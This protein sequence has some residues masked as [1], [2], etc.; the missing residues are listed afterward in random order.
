MD[1]NN[2][3]EISTN[4]TFFDVTFKNEEWKD[5][6]FNIPS[7][8]SSKT[9]KVIGTQSKNGGSINS[10]PYHKITHEFGALNGQKSYCVSKMASENNK[11][12]LNDFKLSKIS[13]SYDCI[14]LVGDFTF[15]FYIIQDDVLYLSENVFIKKAYQ[16]TSIQN[17]DQKPQDFLCENG[18]HPKFDQGILEYGFI[19]LSST[20]DKKSQYICGI[21][22]FTL[23]FTFEMNLLNTLFKIST[24]KEKLKENLEDKDAKLKETSFTLEKISKQLSKKNEQVKQLEDKI[25]KLQDEIKQLQESNTMI[26]D[27][28]KDKYDINIDLSEFT[29]ELKV[30]NK[31]EKPIEKKIEKKE[32]ED[33]WEYLRRGEIDKK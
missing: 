11:M 32:N 27:V 28:E 22:N 25:F 24:E 9:A 8:E 7:F 17:N 16:W 6:I 20:V 31:K 5:E 12:N 10:G 33:E 23:I 21:S 1:K 3:M 14:S 4:I 13:Y 2:P 30:I 26:I 29:K 18:T 15:Y 19:V